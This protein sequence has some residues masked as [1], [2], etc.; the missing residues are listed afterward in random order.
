[1]KARTDQEI[2]LLDFAERLARHTEDRI[3]VHIHLSRLGAHYRR[4]H[5]MRIAMNSFELLAKRFDGQLFMMSNNDLVFIARGAT[6]SEI[7][8]VV[9][10][11]RYLFNEDPLTHD[12]T[13][14][15]GRF[16]TW[17]DLD[18]EYDAF[19]ALAGSMKQQAEINRE[20]QSELRKARKASATP[21]TPMRP[22]H[23]GRLVEQI[24]SMDI[25]S[26]MRRQPICAMAPDGTLRPVFNE[27]FVSIGDLNRMVMPEVNLTANTY[28]FSYLTQYLDLRILK[29]L[30]EIESAVPLSTSI[31]INIGTIL[32]PE[33][34]EFDQ[35]L[36]AL[37][38]KTI[39][40]EVQ[41]SDL[42]ADV[43]SF[44]FARDFVRN[45]G[46]RMCVDGLTHLTFPLIDKQ[47]LGLDMQKLIW[48]ADA[49]EDGG[50]DRRKELVDAI[51]RTGTSR[52]ILCRCDSED[53]FEF[54]R[55]VGLS[56]FQGR[57][58]DQ[59]LSEANANRKVA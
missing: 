18:E 30:P 17:Y 38:R 43:G 6:P 52:V 36:R 54:G 23:L 16:C 9:S 34:L 57:L 31:N 51:R 26:L 59:R 8:E 14:D 1:M 49:L 22:Q 28:L 58:V 55:S 10:R 47:K 32:S 42:F 7:D 11:L 53:A 4:A 46:Y 40:L 19:L 20:R 48:S 29:A 35:R 27:L 44:M 13:Q 2:R 45:R 41:P 12:D 39:V 24:A 25:S 56:L 3:A 50:P 15:T 5:H 37:T 21:K 33:F